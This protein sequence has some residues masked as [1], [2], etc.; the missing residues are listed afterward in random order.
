MTSSFSL[1]ESEREA[2]IYTV[3][4]LIH[5]ADVLGR[6]AERGVHAVSAAQAE[7]IIAAKPER[8]TVF[9][10]RAHGITLPLMEKLRAAETENENI[11]VYDYTCPYVRKIHDIADENTAGEN[12][13]ALLFG[14]KNHPEVQGIASHIG[15]PHIIFFLLRGACLPGKCGFSRKIPQ[16]SPD[17]DGSD[18]SKLLGI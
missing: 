14:D 11:S 6:L 17:N 2:D 18:H 9:I 15:C 3:G 8:K 1:A 16:F 13:A 10:I 5:N 4:E 7:E 12:T